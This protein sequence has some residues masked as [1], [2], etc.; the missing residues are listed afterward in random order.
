M[1]AAGATTLRPCCRLRGGPGWGRRR[2]ER[3]ANRCRPIVLSG[4]PV[5]TIGGDTLAAEVITGKSGSCDTLPTL[6]P[7]GCTM[8]RTHIRLKDHGPT[9]SVRATQRH[10]QQCEG[11]G[12]HGALSALEQSVTESLSARCLGWPAGSKFERDDDGPRGILPFSYR[13]ATTRARIH[14]RCSR[15]SS[16]RADTRRWHAQLTR[17]GSHKSPQISGLGD[18]SSVPSSVSSPFTEGEYPSRPIVKTLTR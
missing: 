6:T 13:D 18:P 3:R 4:T 12:G 7:L 16:R 8:P 10:G 1:S 11:H 5:P 15:K 14:N 17:G 9:A 2:L